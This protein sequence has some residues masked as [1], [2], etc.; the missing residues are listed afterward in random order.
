M[1]FMVAK[2]DQYL[3]TWKKEDMYNFN[4]LVPSLECGHFP[5]GFGKPSKSY[6]RLFDICSLSCQK[7]IKVIHTTAQDVIGGFSAI[8]STI[9]ND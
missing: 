1:H 2:Q 9:R 8:A 3:N 5:C 4:F 7:V 6:Q